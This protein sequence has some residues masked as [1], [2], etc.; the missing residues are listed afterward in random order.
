MNCMCKLGD[1]NGGLEAT[2]GV[3]FDNEPLK[4][5]VTQLSTT[6]REWFI[7]K[8]HNNIGEM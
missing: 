6:S 2:Y 4:V 5:C 7:V 1:E 3:V 8:Y